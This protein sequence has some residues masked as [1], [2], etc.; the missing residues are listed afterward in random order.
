MDT[1]TFIERLN[2]DLGTEYQSIVQYIQHIATIKG[3][4][5]HAIT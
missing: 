3:P 2:E 5:Y 4:E 1:S